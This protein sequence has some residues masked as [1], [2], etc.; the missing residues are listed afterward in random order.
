MRGLGYLFGVGDPKS[1]AHWGGKL[2][3]MLLS[4]AWM[5]TSGS[6]AVGSKFVGPEH[7]CDLRGWVRG[8]VLS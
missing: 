5:Y 7:V 3:L 6:F 8:D 4:G 2:E 1:G